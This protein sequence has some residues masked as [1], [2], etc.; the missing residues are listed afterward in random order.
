MTQTQTRPDIIQGVGDDCAVTLC[1]SPAPSSL[2]HSVKLVQTVD[3]FRSFL[4]DSFVMGQVCAVHALSDVYAMNA[5]A[6]SALAMV[7]LPYGPEKKV[8]IQ[9][10]SVS[11]GES[12]ATHYLLQ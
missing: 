8:R 10:S 4:S 11:A 3:F 9:F 2:S 7:T 6:H 5:A 1:P 12:N